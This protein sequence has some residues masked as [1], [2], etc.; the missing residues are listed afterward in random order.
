MYR[1]PMDTV[2]D[3][4]LQGDVNATLFDGPALV[5]RVRGK[6]LSLNGENQYAQTN[7]HP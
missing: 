2:T 1:L 7:P 5:D 3:N 4:I 6:A